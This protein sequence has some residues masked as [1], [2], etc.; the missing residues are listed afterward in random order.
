MAR[1]WA[2]VYVDSHYDQDSPCTR[3]GEVD[4]E[5]QCA[6]QIDVEQEL[7]RLTSEY[8]TATIRYYSSLYDS[9]MLARMA[10]EAGY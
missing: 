9:A 6:R 4:A 5:C 10:R 3:C 1:Y 2:D 8:N 7:A